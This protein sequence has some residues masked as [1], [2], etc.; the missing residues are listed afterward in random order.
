MAMAVASARYESED[1]YR[2]D[3][4]DFIRGPPSLPF[5]STSFPLF[6]N[7]QTDR[8]FRIFQSIFPIHFSDTYSLYIS[9]NQKKN[10]DTNLWKRLCVDRSWII[11]SVYVDEND[12]IET[13][14]VKSFQLHRVVSILWHN[15]VYTQRNTEYSTYTQIQQEVR[16]LKFQKMIVDRERLL[17]DAYLLSPTILCT[18]RL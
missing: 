11:R 12:A 1:V 3:Y 14:I 17:F 16:R 6:S 5:H 4:R 8:F 10:Q 7:L 15:H 18:Y 9:S 13:V 2:I